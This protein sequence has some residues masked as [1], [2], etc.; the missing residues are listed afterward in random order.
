MHNVMTKKEKKDFCKQ[1]VKWQKDPDFIH[2]AC[3]FVLLT[4]S[5]PPE[6]VKMFNRIVHSKKTFF[7]TNR[8]KKWIVIDKVDKN[9]EFV[10]AVFEWVKTTY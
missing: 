2:A 9:P 5:C 6:K 1:I 8:S 3:E 4:T 7:K 10:R